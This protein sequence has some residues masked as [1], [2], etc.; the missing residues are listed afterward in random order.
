MLSPILQPINIYEN[1]SGPEY[2][3]SGVSQDQSDECQNMF[4]GAVNNNRVS[5]MGGAWLHLKIT[6]NNQ[7]RSDQLKLPICGGGANA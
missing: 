5:G 1:D 4:F 6:K 7:G 3:S 2:R